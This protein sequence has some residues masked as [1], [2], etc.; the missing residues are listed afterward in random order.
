MQR[1]AEDSGRGPRC[2]GSAWP[3]IVWGASTSQ[4]A[5]HVSLEQTGRRR[6]LVVPS[7][8]LAWRLEAKNFFR[9]QRQ[10]PGFLLCSSRET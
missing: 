9:T 5:R 8:G 6:H 7:P 4:P 10:R 1:M 2:G 3:N